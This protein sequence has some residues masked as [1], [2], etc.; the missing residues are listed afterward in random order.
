MSHG[1]TT[2]NTRDGDNGVGNTVSHEV[3][4]DKPVQFSFDDLKGLIVD[5]DVI[6]LRHCKRNEV[7]KTVLSVVFRIDF[8]VTFTFLEFSSL[9]K[10]GGV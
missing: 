5:S 4:T 3:V 9:T 10:L 7:F 2:T 8:Q 6:W 1:C